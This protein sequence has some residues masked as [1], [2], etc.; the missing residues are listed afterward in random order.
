[1]EVAVATVIVGVGLAALMST[2]RA[3]TSANDAST[4][5]TT[6]LFLA[7]NIHEWTRKLPFEDIELV[8]NAASLVEPVRVEDLHNR[9]FSAPR[10]G[11]GNP[12]ATLPGWS[13]H[14]FMEL[15]DPSNL[16]PSA[17]HPPPAADN[18][19][20]AVAI[21]V[22]IF[23]LGSPVYTMRYYVLDRAFGELWVP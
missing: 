23:H 12:I 7:Q 19:S 22:N 21:T 18:P 1:L 8:N 6:A 13:Q 2:L 10:D 17:A 4:K 15:R 3:G 16:I 14:V 11:A 20:G 9:T 5:M